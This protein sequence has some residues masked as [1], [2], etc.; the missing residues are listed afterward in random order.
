MMALDGLNN[1][2]KWPLDGIDWFIAECL[3]HKPMVQEVNLTGSN[4]DPL[5]YKHIKELHS[6]LS[7]H[8][9][10]LKFGI[11]TNGVMAIEMHDVIQLFNHEVSISFPSFDNEHY[12]KMMGHGVPPNIKE[13]HEIVPSVTKVNIVLSPFIVDDGDI[14]D[15]IDKLIEIGVEKINLREP[16][17]QPFVGNPIKTKESF[18]R[19]NMPVYLFGNT[20]IMYWD[21]HTVEVESINLYANGNVSTTYPV[22]KG[23]LPN[24]GGIVNDQ[25][26]WG[27]HKRHV[28][29]WQ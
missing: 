14:Y 20:E 18:R 3:A 24:D 19:F 10:E 4:T 9:K 15:T 21:V 17:G 7:E 13:I 6:Y 29:Q 2:N 11:R 23:H 28:L 1:L 8:M 26:H 5:L 12:Q 25:S 27:Q 16:Y 22:T